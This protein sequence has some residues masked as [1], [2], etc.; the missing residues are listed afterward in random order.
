MDEQKRKRAIWAWTMYDW[1]NS[2]FATTIMA[3]VLPVYYTSVAAANLP[4]NIATA[5]WGFTTSISALLAAIISPILGAMADFS[6]AKKRYL[7]IFMILGVTGTALLYFVRTGDWLLGSLFFILGNIGFAGSLVYYDALLPHVARP[8]ELDQVSSRGY[9]MGYIGGG[10]LLAINLA[11]ILFV[12]GFF[13]PEQEAEI[14]QLMTRMAFLTVAVWWFIFTLPLLNYVSEPKR[15][16]LPGEEKFNPVQA[17]FSRLSTTFKEIRNYRD[18]SIFLLAFWV[19]AN[20]IGTI[21]TMATAYGNE[22]GIGQ[23][24]LIG[25]L[26]M[27]QFLAAPFAILFG[28]LAK[29]IGP[30]KAIYLSL[31]VYTLISIMGYFLQFEWQFWALGALVATVQGGSQALSRSVMGRMIPKSKSAEFFGFFSVFEKFANIAGPF[32]FGV[33]STLTGASR[34]SIVSLIFFFGIGMYLLSRVNIER[35]MKVAE[36]E[37]QTLIDQDVLNQPA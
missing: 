23:T 8:D 19:Y 18:L 20:G 5:Y 2:A 34:L 22:I 33:V 9:A 7:T 14:T 21:I 6:G 28:R 11:M 31:S 30:K 29:R 37:E 26:L 15:R 10:V 12:P 13:P 27:V 25:T 35:G 24:T 16:I 4:P 32:L 36:L 17:S 1:A 3:A